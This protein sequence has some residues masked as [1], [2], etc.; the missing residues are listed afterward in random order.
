MGPVA[1][2]EEWYARRRLACA[3]LCIVMWGKHIAREWFVYNSR[4][5][6]KGAAYSIAVFLDLLE[7]VSFDWAQQATLWSDVGRHFRSA[8]AISTLGYEVPTRCRNAVANM[9]I[10]LNLKF[11]MPRHFKNPIDR[12]LGGQKARIQIFA[13]DC[14]INTVGELTA[15]Q[16]AMYDVSVAAGTKLEREHFIDF[17]PAVDRK[18]FLESTK[19][20]TRKSQQQPINSCFAWT[21]SCVDKRR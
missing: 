7:R 21:F 6:E 3:T 9:P 20:F 16:Q 2:T 15:A 13:K 14:K 1:T 5:L 17:L 10:A 12:F 8:R 4:V 18:T 11:G 19:V